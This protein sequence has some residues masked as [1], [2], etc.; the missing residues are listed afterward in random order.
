MRFNNYLKE[1]SFNILG[2]VY[3]Y[4]GQVN[5][6]LSDETIQKFQTLGKKMGIKV[7]KSKTFQHQLKKAGK[8]VLELMRLVLDYSLHAHILDLDALKKLKN[9]IKAQFAKVKKEDVISFMVNIDKTFLG[10]TSI[11]RHVLQNLLG[12]TVS[13]YDNWQSNYDYVEK[14]MLKIISVLDDMG[15]KEN[16]KLA[17]QIY[18]NVTGKD[19]P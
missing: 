18:K 9:D 4:E 17:K 3:L 19:V 12:I 11:P 16:I 1:D 15:D 14:N 7:R 10:L 2:F 6:A 5:E 13:T 8:G